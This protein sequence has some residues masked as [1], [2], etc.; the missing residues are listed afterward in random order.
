M[1][2]FGDGDAS[3]ANRLVRRGRGG[4]ERSWRAR[5]RGTTYRDRAEKKGWYVVARYC[6][7]ALLSFSAWPGLAVA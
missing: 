6:F 5:A 1:F 7:L 3:G 2:A 4:R